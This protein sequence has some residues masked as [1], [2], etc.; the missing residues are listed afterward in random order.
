MNISSIL[1]PKKLPVPA[2][3]LRDIHMVQRLSPGYG[4]K[5]GFDGI[6]EL[7]YMGSTEMEVAPFPS[8]KRI[9]AAGE[10]AV[11]PF[12]LTFGSTTRDVYVVG[13]A[14]V[15]DAAIERIIEWSELTRPFRAI[16]LTYFEQRFDDTARDHV[17]TIAWWS[18]DIDVAWAL[19]ADTAA[20]LL[21]GFTPVA[22]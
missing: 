22:P 20:N 19:D 13:A 15:L 18:Y 1:R 4:H 7:E 16:E 6:F 12:P 10:L 17:R 5:K 14:T 8:L 3:P 9:R 21:T 11:R 2:E